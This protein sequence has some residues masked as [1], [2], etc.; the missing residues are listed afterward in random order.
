MHGHPKDTLHPAFLAPAAIDTRIFPGGR[1]ALGSHANDEGMGAH[2]ELWA[3]QMAGLTNMEA[4]RTARISGAEAFGVQ[5]DL[6]SIEVGKIVDLIILNKN[7]LDDIHNSRE[8]RYVMKDSILYDGN[9]LDEMWPE[10]KKWSKWRMP[11][12]AADASAI[13]K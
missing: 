10:Q 7:P 3:L 8:I 2:N 1:L 12:K 9:T 5:Q 13:E 6:G 11:K 4:L